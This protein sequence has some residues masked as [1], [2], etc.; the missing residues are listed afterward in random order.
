M[1]TTK[2]NFRKEENSYIANFT[3]SGSCVIQMYID[4]RCQVSVY[5]NIDG[6]NPVLLNNIV[7]PLSEDI[8]FAC[9]IASGIEVTIKTTMEVKDAK[10]LIV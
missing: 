8:I 4:K 6:M 3:S 10:M 9:D 2:L 7:N 5:A 1:A